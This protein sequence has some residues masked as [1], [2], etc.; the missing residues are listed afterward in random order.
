M[1]TVAS[2][3]LLQSFIPQTHI[4]HQLVLGFQKPYLLPP[5]VAKKRLEAP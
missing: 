1:Q 3:R 5:G 2:I 4:E